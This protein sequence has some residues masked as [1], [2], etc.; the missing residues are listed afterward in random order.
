MRRSHKPIL[1]RREIVVVV[2]SGVSIKSVF[3]VLDGL[4]FPSLL[5]EEVEPDDG[6][7]ADGLEV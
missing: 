2:V 5:R 4:L 3:E 7:V 1:K 6:I